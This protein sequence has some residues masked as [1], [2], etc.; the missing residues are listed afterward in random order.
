MPG[1]SWSHVFEMRL[2]KGWRW[3]QF[4]HD[5]CRA[6]PCMHDVAKYPVSRESCASDNRTCGLHVG[7]C[8]IKGVFVDGEK[9]DGRHLKMRGIEGEGR[10]SW[11]A[12]SPD[13]NEG[14]ATN[15]R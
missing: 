7:P 15:L 8:V 13:K 14:K 12:A 6:T 10:F 4:S 9:A 3:W 1:V 5:T 2:G 11:R